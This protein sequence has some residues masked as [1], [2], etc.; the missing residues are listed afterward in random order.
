[1]LCHN[2]RFGLLYCLRKT[3]LSIMRR[4]QYTWRGL[5]CDAECPH[6][7][8]FLKYH[9]ESSRHQPISPNLKPCMR[10]FDDTNSLIL[11][12]SQHHTLWTLSPP[13][14]FECLLT[15]AVHV[16]VYHFGIPSMG[17]LWPPKINV[18]TVEIY[19]KVFSFAAPYQRGSYFIIDG[20]ASGEPKRRHDVAFPLL[21]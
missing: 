6:S 12:S 9:P 3:K 7:I 16:H 17:K 19:W 14:L 15:S 2:N 20:T 11:N 1:M 4:S 13:G 18:A 21:T 5:G 10:A 8:Q